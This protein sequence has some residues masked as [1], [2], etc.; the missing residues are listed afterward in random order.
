M[1]IDPELT[2]YYRRLA[3]RYAGAP[4]PA[5][6]AARRTRFAEIAAASQLPDPEGIAVRDLQIPLAGRTLDARLFQPQGEARPRLIVYFHGG[7][8]VIGSPQTHHTV[9]AL[10][11]EDTGC[12][13][14]SV[15]Y[16]LAPEHPFPAPCEDAMEAVAWLA[17]Q[18]EALGLA[19]AFLALAGDS[20]GGHLAAQAAQQL[21]GGNAVRVDAQLLIYP[22]AAPVL[23]TESYRAFADGPGLTRDEM[24]WFWTQFIGAGAL[25]EGAAHAD[26]RVHLMA[27][28]PVRP[29]ATVIVVAAHDVLRDDG[30]AYADF[31][32][33]HDAAVITIEASGMVH[34]FARLQPEA[35]RA[36]EWMRRAADAFRDLLDDA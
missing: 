19:P 11:A 23:A 8:W 15:D 4:V 35:Q 28:A 25:A 1:A 18:R 34:G 22:V 14:V 26:P 33:R 29:P 9:A 20:A 16:R 21:N 12:A 3:E 30:L 27:A 31:L 17:G 6:A 13:V 7:G 32:V 10:L 36:R 24:A 2:A 5:D